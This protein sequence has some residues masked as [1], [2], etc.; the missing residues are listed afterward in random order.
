MLII[1]CGYPIFTAINVQFIATCRKLVLEDEWL[2][3]SL[4]ISIVLESEVQKSCE[5][6][7]NSIFYIY[8]A[9]SCA[10]LLLIC[11][12]NY[13]WNLRKVSK[14]QVPTAAM[15]NRSSWDAWMPEIWCWQFETVR[16]AKYFNYG[17]SPL[18]WTKRGHGNGRIALNYYQFSLGLIHFHINWNKLNKGGWSEMP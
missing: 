11:L 7:M 3:V 12:L 5:V 9:P 16:S 18:G 6:E 14:V 8:R 1:G 17:I 4:I 2:I 15:L 10:F 13:Q